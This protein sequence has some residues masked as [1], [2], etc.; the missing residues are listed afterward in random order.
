M[1]GLS[2]RQTD[3]QCFQFLEREGIYCMYLLLFSC[4]VVSD[5]LGPHELQHSRLPCPSLFPG[6][7]S[8]SCP[9]NQ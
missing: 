3:L 2:R 5:S 8:N 6:V 4:S 7:C 1:Q 9:L